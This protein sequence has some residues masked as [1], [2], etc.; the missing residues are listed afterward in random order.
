MLRI[1]MT[2]LLVAAPP[3]E[4]RRGSPG[5]VYLNFAPA[6]SSGGKSLGVT[7]APT[8]VPVHPWIIRPDGTG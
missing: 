1:G 7:S 2:R 6:W 3:P 8:D 5:P 4:H